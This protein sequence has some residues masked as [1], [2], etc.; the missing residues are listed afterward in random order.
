ME[1]GHLVGL[2]IYHCRDRYALR[3]SKP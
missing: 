3:L 2:F 1:T